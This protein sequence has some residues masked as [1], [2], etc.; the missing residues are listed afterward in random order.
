MIKLKNHQQR[1]VDYL[2]KK[3]YNQRSILLFHFMGTGKTIT[4]LKFLSHFMKK[5][6]FLIVCPNNIIQTWLMEI[7]VLKLN[8]NFF[9]IIDYNEFITTM[10]TL[11]TKDTFIV[12]DE[13]HQLCQYLRIDPL[14]K[15]NNQIKD[16]YE[17]IN[18]Y[19][20]KLLLSGTPIYEYPSDLCH[21]INLVTD[22]K[23][24]PTDEQ[25]FLEKYGKPKYAK[26]II[27]WIL[28]LFINNIIRYILFVVATYYMLIY[29]Q[30]E[31][32]FRHYLNYSG[33]IIEKDTNVKINRENN[34]FR[35][36]NSIYIS[37][38]SINIEENIKRE[39]KELE[40]DV[41]NF[42]TTKRLTIR[43]LFL[44]KNKAMKLVF[45]GIKNFLDRDPARTSVKLGEI[46]DF[47][48][49]S[50]I[51][52]TKVFNYATILSTLIIPL[53]LY[54]FPSVKKRIEFNK[55]TIREFYSINYSKIGKKI[56]RFIS[57]SPIPRDIEHLFPLVSFETIYHS[58]DN[59]QVKIFVNFSD[60]TLS[61][62]ELLLLNVSDNVEYNNLMRVKIQDNINAL[63]N[64]GLKIGNITS[65]IITNDTIIRINKYDGFKTQNYLG[66]N[67]K[68]DFILNKI[69]NSDPSEKIAIYS[70]FESLGT[71]ILSAYLN[72][73]KI[74]H[75]YLDILNS[76]E[77]RKYIL[78]TF[79]NKSNLKKRVI[80]LNPA[81]IEG[82]SLVGIRQFHILEPVD[83]LS[84]Y[85]QIVAR[86]R[87]MNSHMHLPED[88]RNVTVYNHI[89][90]L[91]LKNRWFDYVSIFT[92]KWISSNS[93]KVFINEQNLLAYHKQDIS[94]DLVLFNK[95][96]KSKKETDDFIGAISR[97][98]IE[99]ISDSDLEGVCKSRK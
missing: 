63:K 72:Y 69:I 48:F 55:N 42:D 41:K 30:S 77:E 33:N 62:K 95:L 35:E 68:F 73:N 91:G 81:F 70:N 8:P 36:K 56:G 88:Q 1:V 25:S 21:I 78:E 22:S 10:K 93:W 7:Q 90:N 87:R 65:D 43:F 57:Y 46:Y 15:N 44:I 14:N 67:N 76:I 17:K 3:C 9:Q 58:Y 47:V 39:Q 52:K 29:I 23:S 97:T 92:K 75:F 50:L 49:K 5:K 20:K 38:F 2:I 60:S 53:F 89:C 98:S 19:E 26:A 99:N 74:D 79:N 18:Q 31:Q 86:S 24:F 16:I 82:I 83:I 59:R 85:E 51:F 96:F 28:R 80:V 45:P 11:K 27:F 13:C 40:N 71:E 94:P 37:D 61:E 4:S 66:S 84:K 64:I 32:M 6:K 34:I 54:V 12:L